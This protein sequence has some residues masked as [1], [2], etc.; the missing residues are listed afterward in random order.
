MRL[1][2]FPGILL[3]LIITCAFNANCQNAP[4]EQQG[5]TPY[6]SFEAG[7]IDSVNLM[8]GNVHLRIPL[9]SLPQRGGLKLNYSLVINN[10]GYK[11][12]YHH[13]LDGSSYTYLRAGNIGPV[14][15]IDQSFLAATR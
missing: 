3:F 7:N 15:T 2:K 6:G 9:Y 10:L 8:N 13:D 5:V 4:G 11:Y 1:L 12:I 14:L